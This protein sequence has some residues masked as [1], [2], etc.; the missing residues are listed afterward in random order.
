MMLDHKTWA[1]DFYVLLT[2]LCVGSF[3]NV[4][5]YRL[6]LMLKRQW[7]DE[8]AQISGLNLETQEN[9]KFNLCTPSSHCPHCNIPIAWYEN[10]PVFGWLALRGQ[11]SNC[12]VHISAR[13]PLVELLTGLISLLTV[14]ILGSGLNA[15]LALIFTWSLIALT[16]IDL[17]E[18]LLPDNITL[19]L[20]WLGLLINTQNIYTSAVSSIIGAASGYLILWSIY[21]GFRILT[22]KE[23]M[24]Y[25]D[26]KLLA[27]L[28]AWLGWQ[29]LP[30]IILFSAL[31]G[32]LAGIGYMVVRRKNLAF[33]FGPYLAVAGWVTLLWHQTLISWYLGRG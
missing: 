6:P 24:G 19:P 13:Y 4:V 21:W 7:K 33:P 31:L 8:C 26:F 23:G 12:K 10:I 15:V 16:L 27:A 9:K 5:A 17:D 11:C 32:A 25:G 29:T 22:D 30:L 3:L 20:L 14:I 2:G 18:Q 1:W 28:G